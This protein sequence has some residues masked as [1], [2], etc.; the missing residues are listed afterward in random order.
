MRSLGESYVAICGL[1]SPRLDH[2]D[3]TLA[4]IGESAR[5]VSRIG[6]DW[7]GSVTL[8]FGVA[9]GD[10]DVLLFSAGHTPYDVW[11]RT[12]VVARLMAAAASHDS[13]RVDES[14]YALLTDVEGFEACPPVESDA[15]GRL[16]NWSRRLSAPMAQAAQ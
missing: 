4:W 15:V 16:A 11:G 2:A 5:A 13:A 9:S 8:R 6:G 10:V 12:L 1:S 3:R 14:A 7:A